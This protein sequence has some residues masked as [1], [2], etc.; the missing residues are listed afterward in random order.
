[1]EQKILFGN[2]SV[3]PGNSADNGKKETPVASNIFQGRVDGEGKNASF[4]NWD[5]VPPNQ[6]INPRIRKQ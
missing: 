1:M 6:F 3:Q 4:P 2:G 5:I